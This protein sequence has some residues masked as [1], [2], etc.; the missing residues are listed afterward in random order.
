MAGVESPLRGSVITCSNAVQGNYFEQNQADSLDLSQTV[1]ECV[2]RA[3]TEE[4]SL[5]EMRALLGQFMFKDQ[6]ADKKLSVLSGGEKARVALCRMLLRPANLLILDEP[7]NHLDITAKE[8]LEEAL[9][10][11]EGAILVISHDRYFLS[12]VANKIFAFEDGRV[13]RYDCDYHDYLR[14]KGE[15]MEKKVKGRVVVGDPTGSHQI[16]RAHPVPEED[17]SRSK[18]NFGGSAGCTSGNLFKGIKNA[19]R[20]QQ[21]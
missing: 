12:K 13:V 20:M 19:K 1:L 21:R 10:Q 14:A 17:T 2:Q 3:S 11:F 18:K 9:S 16:A 4:V 15:D 7:T 5:T 6:A 8:V